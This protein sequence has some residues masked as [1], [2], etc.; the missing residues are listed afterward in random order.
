[1]LKNRLQF[2]SIQSRLVFVIGLGL[3]LVGGVI[4]FINGYSASNLAMN[5][6][7]T[8]GLQSAQKTAYQVKAELEL[9]MDASR[10]IASALSFVKDPGTPMI[11]IRDQANAMLRRV[12][13]DNPNFLG[14]STGWEPNAF[15]NADKDFANTEAHD[16]TGRFI[17]Y[18]VRDE[19]GAISHVALV[20]YDKEGAGEYYLCPKR[21]NG[22]CILDP[23]LYD[24][25]GKQVLLTSAMV[26]IKNQDKFYGVV[27]VDTTLTY[28]QNMAEK[29]DM[30]E[31]Q[32]EIIILSSNGTIA[33]AGKHPEMIGKTMVDF[34]KFFLKSDIDLV[35]SGKEDV[36][37]EGSMLQ[38]VTPFQI[39]KAPNKWSVMFLVPISI[40]T[41]EAMQ[42]VINGSLVGLGL[43]VLGLVVMWFI[44]GRS[45]SKPVK[46]L[47]ASASQIALGDINITGV[48]KNE[49]THILDM[50]DEIGAIGHAFSDVVKYQS[51]MANLA[52]K[53]AEGDLTGSITP[54][55]ETD[56][57]GHAF[58]KMSDSLRKALNDVAKSAASVS[59]SS[60]QLA[61]NSHQAGQATSQIA[62][63]IQQVASGTSQQA[64]SISRTAASVAEMTNAID[65]VARGAQAQSEDISKAVVLTNQLS[66]EIQKVAGNAGEVVRESTNASNAARN[67]VTIVNDTLQG[68]NTIK[69]KVDISAKKVQEMGS[70]SDQIGEI[71]TTIEDIASQTN[72]LA[73]N[74]AIEAARAG[75]AGKG[76]AVVADEVRKLAERSATATREIGG[77]IGGIQSTVNEAVKAMQ[78]GSREVDQ[79]VT[80]AGQAGD[81]LKSIMDAAEEVRTQAELAAN[82]TTVMAK[83]AEELVSAVDSVSAVVEENTAATE[84]MTAS[85]TEVSQSIEN[86]AS[87]SEENSAAVE[88]VSASTEEMSAQVEEVSASASELAAQS[89]KLQDVV[90]RFKI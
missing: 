7:R 83:S 66:Q 54:K 90:S 88:Q 14:I 58:I 49:I 11:L 42:T 13:E 73:L 67:G 68:M 74:A 28:L 1:M 25:G 33:A 89:G 63:T 70:R 81:A 57:L 4:I 53:I 9:G 75:D 26:P 18:W 80:K 51:E 15:D 2:H 43:I 12:L 86:I 79:G 3:L 10:A 78:E 38:V 52:A 59:E 87:I 72:L 19:K 45:I 40:L 32:A 55:G 64:A 6:A 39:G 61:F 5:S 71:I 24:I 41:R 31:G 46:V 17:P 65:G 34:D 76:F 23:Y 16:A 36:S 69:E 48:D 50:Q 56:V 37:V 35:T 20:D 60:T 22:E 82:A 47:A 84:E 29:M 30:Y 77:L 27:G 85:S 62:M 44:I 8:S 21:T